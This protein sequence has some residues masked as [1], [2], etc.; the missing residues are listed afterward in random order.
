M[1]P[2]RRWSAL[3]ARAVAAFVAACVVF[4]VGTAGTS[5]GA[6]Q[7]AYPETG[8]GGYRVEHHVREISAEWNVPEISSNSGRGH[9]ST[10]IGTQETTEDSF[11]FQVGTTENRTNASDVYQAFWS[12]A[13]KTFE[14]QT[15]MSVDPGDLVYA[16]I[17]EKKA[18]WELTFEDK[19]RSKSVTRL[20]RYGEGLRATS[21]EWLQ[22]DPPPS[23]VSQEDWPYPTESIVRF[24]D[25]RMNGRLP[26]LTRVDGVVLSPN[27]STTSALVPTP[28]VGDA[29]TF[30]PPSGAAAQYLQDAKT[31]DSSNSVFRADFA[32]W[33]T[34]AGSAR[35]LDLRNYE[36]GYT[37]FAAAL[38]S[39]QWPATVSGEVSQ[40]EQ[41]SD[42]IAKEI[43]L[44]AQHG[45][46]SSGYRQIVSP[47]TTYESSV[48]K[49]RA[50]LGLPPP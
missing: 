33:S 12:A 29:F 26:K 40:V 17:S 16:G 44:W 23:L 49:L 22:E 46:P 10:W 43:E 15:I 41:G 25:V 1:V 45:A 30:V 48:K 31:A 34:T 35:G 9:A 13:S 6:P 38:A 20:I 47:S 7:H 32:R 24:R 4:A 28:L 18:G 8:F 42:Q 50:S 11:F 21:G 36:L 37:N 39:Q 27:N 2:M 14:P 19:T 5:Q 3:L